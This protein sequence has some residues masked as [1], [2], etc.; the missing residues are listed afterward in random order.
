MAPTIRYHEGLFY[1]ICANFGDKGNFVITTK[2]PA[3]QWSEMRW[4]DEINDIDASL[5]FDTDGKAYI[6]YPSTVKQ[7]YEKNS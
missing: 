2:K 1:I 3:G 5:F 4:I 7:R 6:V